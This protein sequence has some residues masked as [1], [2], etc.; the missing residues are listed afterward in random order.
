MEPIDNQWQ[1]GDLTPQS[2]AMVINIPPASRSPSP[3]T[4]TLLHLDGVSAGLN[5][6]TQ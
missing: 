2:S 3:S 4:S 6:L 1:E 5:A